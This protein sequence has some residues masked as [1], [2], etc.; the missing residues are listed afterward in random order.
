MM[1][2]DRLTQLL[3]GKT[4]IASHRPWPRYDVDVETW[5]AIAL[6]LSD[7]RSDL[8]GLWGDGGR[9]HLALRSPARPSP[10]VISVATRNGSFPSVGRYAPQAIRLERVIRD[11]YGYQPAGS[12]DRRAWI[13]HGA[14]PEPAP[15]ADAPPTARKPAG[16]EFLPARGEG[17]HQVAAG[18]VRAGF[19]EPG[20]FRFTVNGETVVRLEA[21]LGYA[22]RGIDKLLTDTGVAS[23]TRLVARVCGD[24]TVAYGV[25]F[26][27]AVEAALRIEP[28][29]RAQILR[30]VMAELE[31]IANHLGGIGNVCNIAGLP[32]IHARCG[33]LRERVL[34]AADRA[35]GHRLM[36]DRVIPGGVEDMAP[37]GARG[38]LMTLDEIEPA[39]AEVASRYNDTPSLQ[40]R[41]RGVGTV[42]T[43]LAAQWA[44]GGFV[45]RAS[46]RDFDARRD[47]PYAP[48]AGAAFDV[49][50]LTAGDVDARVQVRI[51]EVAQS[52]RLLRGWLAELPNGP[53]KIVV[54]F[55]EDICEGVA[56]AEAFRGDVLVWVRIENGRIA[57]CCARDA[58]VF[59][60]PLVE[61]AAGHGTLAD[62][63]L[64][65]A[66]FNCSAAGHDL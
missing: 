27:R 45:G 40:N 44:A 36:M 2:P 11:L 50:V 29:A 18:P 5:S 33:V 30:G 64:C 63:P 38:I 3:S 60:W 32:L 25:A 9:V 62:F 31:R 23:A 1:M 22:H 6:A 46:G 4:P 53:T 54:P 39:F 52:I 56:M 55:D 17:L 61:A 15:L 66:S 20:H 65:N 26:A 34:A 35:F 48:Y 10:C 12:P 7:G 28:P 8:L 47:L 41:T 43:T 42:S 57:R 13:D 16:Y 14:W 37:G 24:S 58:S 51:R 59:Q 19:A 49:P 21:R